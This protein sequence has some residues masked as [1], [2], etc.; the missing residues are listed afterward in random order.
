MLSEFELIKRFFAPLSP[1]QPDVRVGIGDDA[2]VLKMPSRHELV[3]STDTL[4]EG[5][6]FPQDAEPQ[7]IAYKALASNLSDLAA[8]GATPR[9]FTLALTLPKAQENWLKRF[10]EGLKACAKS[11]QI[12]LVGGDTTKGPLLSTSITV[13]GIVPVGDAITRSG[14]ES[15]DLVVVTG[16]LGDAGYALKLL[17]TF[18]AA[19][20]N[21]FLDRY[22]RPS[23]RIGVGMALRKIA[24]SMIDISDGFSA[25]LNHILEASHVGA[26][27]NVEQLPLSDE[28][29]KSLPQQEAIELALSAGDDY[30]LCFTVPPTHLAALET[31]FSKL[32]CRY[33]Q[34]GKIE[35]TPGL[36]A[37]H[38]DG[39]IH[40]L[41]TKGFKHFK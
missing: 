8:M 24:T 14:A 21:Y 41:V 25:D 39:N 37:R 22:W 40:P 11:F 9:W 32:N 34:V 20:P 7:K 30:E 36:K 18:S 3:V 19:T 5:V 27:V 33:T 13:I 1:Q 4:V 17:N 35:V 29:V 15:G 10:S 28:L 23:P 6:H 16:T 2:A 31:I 26:T 38:F 12:G